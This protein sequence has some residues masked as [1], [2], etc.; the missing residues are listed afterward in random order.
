MK[1]KNLQH[2]CMCACAHGRIIFHETVAQLL[3]VK[4]DYQI[5]VTVSHSLAASWYCPV[6]SY[7]KEKLLTNGWSLLLNPGIYKR[8]NGSK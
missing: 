7:E 2:E 5:K 4:D 6:C 3:L 8:L 1:E